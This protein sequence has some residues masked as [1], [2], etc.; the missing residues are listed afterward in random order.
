M[1]TNR[2][3]LT[4]MVD[5]VYVGAVSVVSSSVWRSSLST[6][7]SQQTQRQSRAECSLTTH[8]VLCLLIPSIY[9]SSIYTVVWASYNLLY[10]ATYPCV[11]SGHI[12]WTL[13]HMNPCNTHTHTHTHTHTQ[14]ITHLSLDFPDCCCTTD[15]AGGTHP[16]LSLRVLNAVL[17]GS[18]ISNPYS[19]LTSPAC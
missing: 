3:P 13:A 4:I 14:S 5:I 15:R 6:H 7:H 16:N 2:V 12:G 18:S 19:V 1:T 9:S 11:C 8:T 10:D 17:C